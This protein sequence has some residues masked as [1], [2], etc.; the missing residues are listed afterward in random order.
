MSLS[1]DASMHMPA[2]CATLTSSDLDD[3]RAAS[4][5]G[6]PGGDVLPARSRTLVSRRRLLTL[7]LLVFGFFALSQSAASADTKD[8]SQVPQ[9][10]REYI[11]DTPEWNTSPW[12]TAPRC[13]DHGGDFSLY[14]Q[15]IL[16]DTPDLLAF[17]QP[18][19]G[20]TDGDAGRARGQAIVRGY[21]EIA[22]LM[23][24]PS[25]YCVD[26]MRQ[27][28]GPN[29]QVKPFGFA[30]GDAVDH[31]SNFLCSNTAGSGA[32]LAPC[33]GFYISCVGA[34][35]PQQH[36]QCEAWN[37]FSDDYVQ[38]VNAAR[39]KA[40]SEYKTN[41]IG[42]TKTVLKS[43]EQIMQSILDWT[44]KKG[45]EQ[46]T[47]F[48]ESGVTKLWATFL[49]I[50]VD[51]STPNLTGAGFA[52]VYNLVAGV[53]L[54]VAFLGWLVSIANSWRQ[55]RLQ[56]TL[57]GGFKAA[58]GVTL[59]GVGAILMLQ[60]ADECTKS[61]AS[62]G[63]DLSKQ[64]DFTQSLVKANPLVAIIVGLVCA[65]CLIFAVIFLVI[66][67]ALVLM[68]ALVGSIAAAGQVHPASSGWLVKWGGRLFA[69]AWVKFLM[70]ADMLLAQALMLPIDAG[71]D[72]VKQIVDVV[73]GLAL[74]V[75][76]IT[77]PYLLLEL[78]DFASDRVGGAHAGAGPAGHAASSG[79]SRATSS[80]G[81]AAGHA[82][83]SMISG[84]ANLA[85][86]FPG[87]KTTPGPQS[88]SSSGSGGTQRTPL[89]AQPAS[90]QTGTTTATPPSGSSS[91]GSGRPLSS[92]T[93]PSTGAS[94]G[95]SGGSAPGSSSG[96]APAPLPTP[97]VANLGRVVSGTG[98]K[99]SG[100]STGSS[101]GGGGPTVPKVPPAP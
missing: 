11:A 87:N 100:G 65:V 49:T 2:S 63:G 92:P 50:A 95:G 84:A 64:A 93:S 74:C 44:S 17:F 20:G 30:W 78:V 4:P 3:I 96:S 26:Q 66:H 23:T 68:W 24:V 73:Q 101:G 72:T 38:R 48:V 33:G 39:N 16:K 98:V 13:K 28:A 62:A 29:A 88:G 83:T 47:A 35:T 58:A 46:V 99:Y 70:V 77:T 60:L 56:Y 90:A 69:L 27:W 79:A 12:I 97:R 51:Y 10:L 32:D 22:S 43:P 15:N 6:P 89:P 85:S 34:A 52:S 18:D 80:V 21:Q 1:P 61:L 54:A 81:G 76:L 37:A 91:G 5:A 67:S 41:D 31:R 36:Q 59:A 55:G 94:S 8:V 75:L 53:A 82:V 45:M 14:V 42:D 25:G 9:N 40:L 7:L 71:E 57:L 19:F 86:K